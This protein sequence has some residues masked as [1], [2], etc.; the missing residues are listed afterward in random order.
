MKDFTIS[1]ERHIGETDEHLPKVP[2]VRAAISWASASIQV[3]DK[4]LDH[5][6]V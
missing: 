4:L 6:F 5:P 3:L 1:V 2:P